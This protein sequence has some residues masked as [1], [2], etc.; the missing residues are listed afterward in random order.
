L[1]HEGEGHKDRRTIL[2]EP[3]TAH[4]DLVRPRHQHDL[5]QGFARVYVPDTLKEAAKRYQDI[6]LAMSVPGTIGQPGHG[7]R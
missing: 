2:Q 3:L 6:E 7:A 4:L 1:V 5:A